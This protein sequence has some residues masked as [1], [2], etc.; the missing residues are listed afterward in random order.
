MTPALS[1]R[2]GVVLVDLSALA[3]VAATWRRWSATIAAAYAASPLA[4]RRDA[5]TRLVAVVNSHAFYA[6]TLAQVATRYAS[7]LLRVARDLFPSPAT[8]SALATCHASNAPGAMFVPIHSTQ[9]RT[10]P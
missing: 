4:K 10:I 7:Q 6:P 2:P 5:K 1:P 9:G 8:R 3:G